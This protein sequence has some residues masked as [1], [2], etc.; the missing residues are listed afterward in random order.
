[1]GNDELKETHCYGGSPLNDGLGAGFAA[2]D[3][4]APGTPC[5]VNTNGDMFMMYEAREFFAVP[6]IVVKRT[7]AGLIMVA[8]QGNQ[9]RTLSF[10]QRNIDVLEAPNAVLSGKPPRTE[11]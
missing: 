4:F 7:K 9:K 1:M 10:P 5:T 3:R 2:R 6:C 11:L 8:L